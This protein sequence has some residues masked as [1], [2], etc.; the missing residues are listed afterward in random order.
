MS[1]IFNYWQIGITAV[2]T[3]VV[4]YGL[5]S[6]DV[7]YLNASN[8][9]KLGAQ[10][11]ALVQSCNVIQQQIGGLSHEY[12]INLNNLDGERDALRLRGNNTS[13]MPS[14]IPTPGRNATPAGQ[15][16]A[17]GNAGDHRQE[18][19]DFAAKAEKYRLQLK[20]CQAVI[21]L[22]TKDQNND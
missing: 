14:V 5:H 22:N 18:L 8:Q 20:S 2:L 11:K 12:Q 4:A 17:A 7:G 19:Y 1:L 6:L 15:G 16:Y 3:A 9:A 13:P 10:Q 21:N